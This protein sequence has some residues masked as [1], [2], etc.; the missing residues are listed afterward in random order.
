MSSG[1]LLKGRDPDSQEIKES[2]PGL[3]FSP[4]IPYTD[5]IGAGR[6]VTGF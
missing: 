2:E 4:R 5:E 3:D 1:A 6:E